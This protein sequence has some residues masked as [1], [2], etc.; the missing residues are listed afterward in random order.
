MERSESVTVR[1]AGYKNR[2]T[3]KSQYPKTKF[4]LFAINA[5]LKDLSLFLFLVAPSWSDS[6][7]NIIWQ[8]FGNGKRKRKMLKI[9]V[10]QELLFSLSLSC[11]AFLALTFVQECLV[12]SYRKQQF[13]FLPHLQDFHLDFWFNEAFFHLQL[14][15][16]VG[17]CL[18]LKMVLIVWCFFT[19]LD[20][21][22]LWWQ[23]N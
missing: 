1:L 5:Q 12:L 4:F 22:F 9:R 16:K 15:K 2:T 10:L 19:V 7:E 17:R 23:I 14:I 21:H 11:I 3:I 13:I 20:F 18:F 8:R 6:G